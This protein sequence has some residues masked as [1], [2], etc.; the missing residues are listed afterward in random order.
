MQVGQAIIAKGAP[1][2]PLLGQ[3]LLADT[4]TPSKSTPIA[5][6]DTSHSH[7]ITPHV[8]LGVLIVSCLEG[9]G[10]PTAYE[11]LKRA[12]LVHADADTRGASLYALGGSAHD[13]ASASADRPDIEI[14]HVLLKCADDS[15]LVASKE[16]SIGSV[17]REGLRNWTGIEL[18]ERVSPTS[19]VPVKGRSDRMPIAAYR[20][21]WWNLAAS[22]FSWNTVTGQFGPK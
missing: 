20:E 13:R 11:V 6:N 3:I 9:I 15:A 21:L 5:A 4:L 14:L 19:T 1:A 12:A 7:Y 22:K 17:A 8:D 10:S 2:V 16:R 18:G